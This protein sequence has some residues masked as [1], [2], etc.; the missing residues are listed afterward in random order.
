MKTTL[1][2]PLC[3]LFLLYACRPLYLQLDHNKPGLVSKV[4]AADIIAK[5]N[6]HVG[7]CAFSPDGSE[8]YYAITN[9]DWAMSKLLRITAGNSATLYLY[10]FL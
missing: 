10:Y 7:Y 2:I 8:F 1:A 9:N 4:F 5:N 6:E 3:S